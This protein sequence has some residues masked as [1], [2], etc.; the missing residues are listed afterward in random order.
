MSSDSSAGIQPKRLLIV[1]DHEMVAH[2]LA[3]SL[4]ATP[5]IRITGVATTA[6]EAI[7]M[8]EDIQPEIALIDVHMPGKGGFEIADEVTRRQANCA[9]LFMSGAYSPLSL[10]RAL[11]LNCAGFIL[12]GDSISQLSSMVSRAARGERVFSRHLEDQL[13]NDPQTGE[14]R[15]RTRSELM[16]LTSRQLEVLRLLAKGLSV[17]E[18]AHE[19]HLS[20][21]AVDSQKYRIMKRLNVH[22]RVELSR[23]AIRE[24]LVEP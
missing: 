22:D 2:A 5:E 10:H 12:K 13:E 24:G 7:R 1:D 17:R 23:L 21:K 3:R 4:E 11:S 6:D 19:M 18:V 14:L 16:S 15:C 8:A 9:L 20:E